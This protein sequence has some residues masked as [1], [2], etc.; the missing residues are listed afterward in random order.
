MRSASAIDRKRRRS[1]IEK[2]W[3][4]TPAVFPDVAQRVDYRTGAPCL[5]PA[6]NAAT[7]GLALTL[8]QTAREP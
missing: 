3:Q 5:A 1:I 4:T 6:R 7:A 8:Q 2:P